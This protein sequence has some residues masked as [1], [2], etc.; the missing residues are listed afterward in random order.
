MVS[1]AAQEQPLG[2]EATVSGQTVTVVLSGDLDVGNEH[3]L[4]G[5]LTKLAEQRPARLVFEM[6]QVGYIG[7][8]SARLI[9]GTGRSLPDGT[10]PVIARPSP[11]VR[12]VLQLTGLDALCDL[13]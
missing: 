7:C 13:Q 5:Q 6:A 10:R 3:A 1:A 8:A 9:T 11:V 12:R 2:F 4:A